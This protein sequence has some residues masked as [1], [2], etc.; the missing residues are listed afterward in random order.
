MS[1]PNQLDPNWDEGDLIAHI[2]GNS[3]ASPD[4][5]A[6]LTE[7]ADLDALLQRTYGGSAR[8][9]PQDLVDVLMGQATPAQR[10]IV[11][12]YVRDSMR[13]K[14][15]MAALEKELADELGSTPKLGFLAD[16]LPRFMATPIAMGIG[17]RTSANIS[18][19]ETGEQTFQVAE[20]NVQITLQIAPPI[21]EL[22][23]IEGYISQNYLPVA[24]APLILQSVPSP[25]QES[26]TDSEGFFIFQE[27]SDGRYN[28]SIQLAEGIITLPELTLTDEDG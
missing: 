26:N 9:D 28:L 13:G 4:L 2:D 5:A 20:L 1:E 3:N 16:L 14:A 15:E 7:L 10:L 12:A 8:P 21:R 19:T 24:D 27:L 23:E 18:A 22:W 11:A 25:Q 6:D 17:L